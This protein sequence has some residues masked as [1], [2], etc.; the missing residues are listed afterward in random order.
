[1]PVRS[2]DGAKCHSRAYESRLD[3]DDASDKVPGV[4]N[5]SIRRRTCLRSMWCLETQTGQAR[6]REGAQPGTAS[7]RIQLLDT[8]R[9]CPLERR[10]KA[11][12]YRTCGSGRIAIS[13]AVG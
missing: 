10:G 11:V 6:M 12:C 3:A 1:M 13:P 5:G 7:H 4:S 9:H 2:E 8:T